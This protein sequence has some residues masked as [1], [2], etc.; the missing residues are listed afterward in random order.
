[1]VFSVYKI[2]SGDFF[3]YGFTNNVNKRLYGHKSRLYGGCD[4]KLYKTIRDNNNVF[5]MNC[6]H[7]YE[8]RDEALNKENL[9]IKTHLDND[10]CM[11]SRKSILTREERLESKKRDYQKY[12]DNMS[13]EDKK[14][15]LDKKKQYMRSRRRK[16][17][18]NKR[19]QFFQNFINQKNNI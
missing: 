10:K 5:D 17:K 4:Y 1:M 9:L 14:V 3:Y 15:F 2:S 19:I 18:F 11:N 12:R 16:E 6:I 7:T 8:N 13:E